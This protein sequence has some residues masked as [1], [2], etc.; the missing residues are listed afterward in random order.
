MFG[1]CHCA[2]DTD[3]LDSSSSASTSG[4]EG[5]ADAPFLSQVVLR[6]SPAFSQQPGSMPLQRRKPMPVQTG[7]SSCCLLQSWKLGWRIHGRQRCFRLELEGTTHKETACFKTPSVV[8]S[9]CAALAEQKHQ[10]KT[11]NRADGTGQ[12]LVSCEPSL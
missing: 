12:V 1:F 2:D 4:R 3:R 8:Q 5:G 11:S 10:S 6:D 9:Q 7:A